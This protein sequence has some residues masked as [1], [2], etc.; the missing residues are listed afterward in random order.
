M[1]IEASIVLTKYISVRGTLLQVRQVRRYDTVSRETTFFSETGEG[2]DSMGAA[3]WRSIASLP[4]DDAIILATV[5]GEDVGE[6]AY[7]RLDLLKRVRADFTITI[8]TILRKDIDDEIAGS[9]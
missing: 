9:P 5:L 4:S 6:S 8:P 3:R 2:V 7:Q 1:A